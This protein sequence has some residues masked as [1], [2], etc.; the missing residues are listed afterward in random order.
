MRPVELSTGNRI[1]RETGE[2][3][4]PAPAAPEPAVTEAADAASPS[5]TPGGEA[6]L[7]LLDMA[8]EAAKRGAEPMRLFWHGRTRQEQIEINKIR[9]E[10]DE[11]VDEA[12]AARE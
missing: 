5:D 6:A 12:E 7:S 10:I 2:V 11:L 1:D 8:R 9:K 4:E 3:I